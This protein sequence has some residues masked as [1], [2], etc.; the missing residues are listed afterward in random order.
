M[1]LNWLQSLLIGLVSGLT[2]ILPVSAQA[3]KVILLKLFGLSS[4]PLILRFMI[5]LATLA[6]LYYC[7]QNQIMRITRQLRLARIPKKRRKRPLDTRTLMDFKLLRMMVIPTVL[8]FFA[9]EKTSVWNH[10]LNWI[11]LLVLANAVILFLPVLMPSGNKDS[12]SFS[13]VEGL[14]IGIGGALG[15]VPGISSMGATTSI[16]LLRGADRTFTLNMALLLQMAV[17]AC[18]LVMDVISM[19]TL[20]IGIVSFGGIVCCILA[21]AAAFAGVFLGVKAM[22]ILAVNIGFNM[23]AFY[24][25][26]V[27]L[28][29]F[30]LFLTA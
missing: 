2:D 28:F 16:L 18:M 9:Y 8:G 11:A 5:H 13:P 29:S 25:L 15:V 3:H 6:G 22:R 4:E 27:A 24:S 20:G 23:F 7:C 14:L 21:A 30:I 1:D 19:S 10:S 12:R 26:G 17:T